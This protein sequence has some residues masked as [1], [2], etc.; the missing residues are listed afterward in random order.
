[1]IPNPM[2]NIFRR[3]LFKS[4]RHLMCLQRQVELQ[5]A[6]ELL[7]QMASVGKGCRINGRARI[8]SPKE[9]RIGDNVHLGDNL[10]IRA[11]G[12]QST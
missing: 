12:E 4:V 3:L 8:T 11:E 1:M 6:Q 5:E 9:I 2:R 7:S 10:F